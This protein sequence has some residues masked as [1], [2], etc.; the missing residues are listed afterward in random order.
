MYAYEVEGLRKQFP[1]RERPANDGI[2]LQISQGE[3][4][5]LIGENGA[6]KTTLIRQMVNL[7]PVSCGS[8]RLFGEPVGKDSVDV[9]LSVGYMPQQGYA[10]NHL[11]VREALY[12]TAHLRGLSRKAAREEARAAMRFWDIGHLRKRD[13]AYLS[14]GERR[15]LRLAVATTANPP[16]LVLDEPTNDLDPLRRKLVWEN[17][18][19]CNQALGAT[20]IFVTHD[21]NEAERIIQRVGIMVAGR[22]IGI[23]RL[24]D[25]KKKRRDDLRID[26]R[27]TDG[28]FPDIGALGT[29]ERIDA[30][31]GTYVAPWSEALRVLGKIDPGQLD[32][33]R[34]QLPTL[35]DI[36]IDLVGRNGRS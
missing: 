15:L 21:T 5:G 7:L 23:G 16:V 3:I 6:G 30:D 26:V 12:F 34:V 20:I 1:G 32:D 9:T 35:E 14:T 18:R 22:L 29:F 24:A 4:F 10:L 2:N 25:L 31:R 33:I 36:Y 8:I 13:S 27:L 19:H 28:Q 11:T 17:L